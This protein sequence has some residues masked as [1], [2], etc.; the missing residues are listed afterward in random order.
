MGQRLNTKQF[1]QI[2]IDEAAKRSPTY[3][4]ALEKAKLGVLDPEEAKAVIGALSNDQTFLNSISEGTKA[5][6]GAQVDAAAGMYDKSRFDTSN[7]SET[8]RSIQDLATA[9][10]GVRQQQDLQ[11]LINPQL[12]HDMTKRLVGSGMSLLPLL[13]GN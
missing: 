13:F 10:R 4:K 9:D 6:I 2:L 8:N 1:N 5:I 11:N 12:R 3:A 7:W